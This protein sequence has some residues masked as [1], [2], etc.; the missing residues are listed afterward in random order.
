MT[1]VRSQKFLEK[2]LSRRTTRAIPWP[3]LSDPSILTGMCGIAGW[4]SA[5]RSDKGVP[6][7]QKV[8]DSQFR[9]GPDHQEVQEIASPSGYCV[10]G[11]NRLSIIDLSAHSNQP[12]FDTTGQ[13]ALVFNGELYNYIELRDELK[14]LG[15]EFRTTGDTEVVIEAYKRW[16][17]NAVERFNGM[18][19]F[20]LLDGRDGS[21][22]LVRDRF[23]VKPLFLARRPE[24]IAFASSGQCLAGE[25]ATGPNWRYLHKGITTLNF[26]DASADCPYEGLEQLKPGHMIVAKPQGDRLEIQDRPWY[27][28]R[29]RAAKLR[30]EIA[31]ESD[32]RLTE[33]VLETFRAAT[34]IRLRADVP[35]AVAL[36]GG[37][38]SGSVACMVGLGLEH[39]EVRGFSFGDPNDH[40]T[41]G[42]LAK[43]LADHAGIG[44]TFIPPDADRVRAA[45][46]PT[47]EAQDAPFASVS[48]VAQYLVAEQVRKEGFLV[49]LGGQG[50]D[51]GYMGYR[52]YFGFVLKEAAREKRYGDLFALATG[53]APTVWAERSQFGLY[54]RHLKRMQGQAHTSILAMPTGIESTSLG[55][56]GGKAWERQM[57]DIT[58]F[59][60]PT[61][62]RY[63]D[64]NSMGHSIETRLP[65]L[66]YR[67]LE[68]GL[69]L[70]ERLKVRHGFGK[71][72]I[73]EAVKSLVPDAVR[74][75]KMK[76]GFAVDQ[77]R[78]LEEGLGDQLRGE[79]RQNL[80]ATQPYVA[81]GFDLDRDFSNTRLSETTTA[82][83]EMLSLI[84]MIRRF[85]G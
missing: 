5:T 36:S 30:E 67:M 44:I 48:Q 52:K 19:A 85:P 29:A 40:S 9:R 82:M 69:A 38:D 55:I 66:D 50:G 68:L 15:H 16:G 73:R 8:V 78:L 17:H 42:P 41:E 60:L 54:R 76:V 24:L 4:F 25:F 75:N 63:E 34:E 62:L 11:H 23:G 51:E 2:Y 32:A 74:I 45:F 13:I 43:K 33:R 80:A 56:G 71:W 7:V 37:L 72:A 77:A 22:W 18:F 20:G 26:D 59:S 64:R 49:L 83:P 53:L 14:A 1:C 12:I 10:F 84:W 6:I 65:F 47:L 70:P 81:P 79:I 3:H 46:L 39:R 58:K 21:L 27:D 61:L 35:V 57:L 31:S 28:L